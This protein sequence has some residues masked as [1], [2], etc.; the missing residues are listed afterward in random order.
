MLLSPTQ[1]SENIISQEIPVTDDYP[2]VTVAR[3]KHFLD[4]DDEVEKPEE[5]NEKKKKK[6]KKRKQLQYSGT[7]LH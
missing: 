1:N 3:G 7:R 4:S 5:L 6:K 2:P